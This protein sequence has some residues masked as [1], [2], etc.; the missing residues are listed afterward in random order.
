[1]GMLLG[2]IWRDQDPVAET[3]KAGNFPL[4]GVKR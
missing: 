3:G 2:G 4:C 1:M